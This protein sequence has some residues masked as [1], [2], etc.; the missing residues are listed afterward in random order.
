MFDPIS[1]FVATLG[2]RGAQLHERQAR[3]AA[4][5]A[6]LDALQARIDALAAPQPP[7]DPPVDPGDHRPRYIREA[8]LMTWATIPGTR[9]DSVLLDP[10]GISNKRQ[11][12]QCGAALRTKTLEAMLL[13]G[14]HADGCS[15]SVYSIPLA[16]EQPQWVRRNEPTPTELIQTDVSHYLDGR[17]SATHTGWTIQY[18]ADRDLLMRFGAT[19]VYGSGIVD[20]P[21]V[22]AF[23]PVTNDWLPAGTFA[24]SP[25]KVSMDRST[26]QLPNGDVYQQSQSGSATI[27]R[28]SNET[29]QWSTVGGGRV[30]ERGP[31]LVHDPERN[32]LVRFDRYRPTFLPLDDPDSIKP[33]VGPDYSGDGASHRWDS[34]HAI[35]DEGRFLRIENG[36]RLWGEKRPL[37][38]TVYETDPD[39]FETSIL[40]ISG[41]PPKLQPSMAGIIF[42]RFMRVDALGILLFIVRED[43]D[44]HFIRTR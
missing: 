12:A 15:N 41:V 9:L 38:V 43:A 22:D 27:T 31:A 36:Y 18:N 11:L 14:G 24:P 19:S 32:R 33:V 26:V 34:C 29:A 13:T 37:D 28:W 16:D 6:R 35:Y 42:G 25:I 2:Q 17:P 3:L 30:F 44:V 20:A 10:R 40:P 7:A 8:P 5:S 21:C 1:D 23:D 4:N 39:T